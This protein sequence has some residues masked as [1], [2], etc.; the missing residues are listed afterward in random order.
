MSP[1]TLLLS[2]LA[3]TAAAAAPAQAKYVSIPGAPGYGPAK[4]AKV[5]V[6]KTGPASAKNV[7]VLIPGTFGGSGDFGLVAKTLVAKIPNLQVWAIDRRANALEDTSSMVKALKGEIT[8]QQLFAYYIGW[9]GD[10]SITTHFQPV[11]DSQVQFAKKWGLANAMED[12]R[13]VVLAAKQGG[14]RV[15][16]GGHSLG[17]SSVYDYATWDFNGHPGYK[18]LVGLVAIDGGGMTT[19]ESLADAKKAVSDLNAGKSPWLDL[20]G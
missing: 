1:R 16:L 4:Y 20:L 18:D 6:D 10:K 13:R 5:F 3:L 19:S 15:I 7:L 17:A 14:R 8:G 12:T 9:L 2:V 11:P